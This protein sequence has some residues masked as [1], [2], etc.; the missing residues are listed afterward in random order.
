M[1]DAEIDSHLSDAKSN[2]VNTDVFQSFVIVGKVKD[3][4][5]ISFIDYGESLF[6]K[7]SVVNFMNE[8]YKARMLAAVGGMK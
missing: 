6:D 1:E 8:F 3:R 4:D 2:L 7:A 5:T